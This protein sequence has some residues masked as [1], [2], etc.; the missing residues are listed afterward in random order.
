M[1]YVVDTGIEFNISKL[2]A[3]YSMVREFFG[4]KQ[5]PPQINIKRRGD[6]PQYLNGM[7]D[8]AGSLYQD[9]KMQAREN[10]WDTYIEMFNG[11]YTKSVCKEIEAFARYT[12]DGKVGRIR[13]MTM[14]PKSVLTYH[15]DPDDVIRLHIPL[16]TNDNCFF[17]NN[18]VISRMDAVGHMYTFDSTV[19][20]TAVNASRESRTHLV[21]SVYNAN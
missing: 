11:T 17:I 6:K 18:E 16:I 14:A 9:G 1:K 2:L 19:K 7:L 15:W 8:F 5:F 12:F 21:A 20:H 4:P 10:E 13:Y 3:D